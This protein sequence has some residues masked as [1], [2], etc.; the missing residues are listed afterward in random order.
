MNK[1]KSVFWGVLVLLLILGGGWLLFTD[2]KPAGPT[3]GPEAPLGASVGPD[4]YSY[5]NVHGPLN[6]REKVITH[7]VTTTYT[8]NQSGSTV[9]FNYATGTTATLPAVSSAGS[10]FRFTVGAA[11][12]DSNMVVASAEGD[13]IE[14][15]LI[16]AGAV[17]DCDG[18]DFIN[19]INDGENVGDFVELRS[20]G[21][22]WIIGAS[23]G[24]TS[25]KMTCTDPS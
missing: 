24:L 18:E 3:Q 14:G 12:A 21:T 20:N 15:T 4:V 16:V 2:D 7:T 6:Y 1:N 23:G 8:T 9:N 22:N 17:V 5:L 13:N 25:A 11:F 10:V 19:F